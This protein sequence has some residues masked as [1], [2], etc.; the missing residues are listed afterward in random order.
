MYQ[1][2]KRAAGGLISRSKKRRFLF[3][4]IAA[5]QF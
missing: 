4:Q 2:P 1:D 3:V 5:A